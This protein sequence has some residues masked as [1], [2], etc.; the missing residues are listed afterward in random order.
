M[1]WLRASFRGFNQNI[2]LRI[3][4][5]IGHIILKAMK[6]ITFLYFNNGILSQNCKTTRKLTIALKKYFSSLS[7]VQFM[8][9]SK[10][11]NW[12]Q[13]LKLLLNFGCLFTFFYLDGANSIK[14]DLHNCNLWTG[15]FVNYKSVVYFQF[16]LPK[17]NSKE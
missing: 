13:M 9:Y 4:G 14:T 11:S 2:Y 12:H 7:K 5:S 6:A 3:R 1:Y 15:Q 8:S 17:Q 16:N 10:C